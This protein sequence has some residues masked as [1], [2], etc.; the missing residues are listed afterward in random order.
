MGT[1]LFFPF[2]LGILVIVSS[3]IVFKKAEKPGWAVLIPIYNGIVF[4]QIAGKPW[5]WLLLFLIP[6]IQFVFLIWAVNLFVKSFGKGTGFTIGMI[7]LSI[8]FLPILAFGDA[9]YIGPAGQKAV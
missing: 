7:F 6:V 4:L 2:A 9:K 8:I 5:W 1:A 3:W